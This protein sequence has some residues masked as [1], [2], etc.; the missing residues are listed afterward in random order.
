MKKLKL[1]A[2]IVAACAAMP[3]FAQTW[4]GTANYG[5]ETVGPFNTYDFSSA[6]VLLIDPV[7][8]TTANGYYQSFVTS[9]LLDDLKISSPL[10]ASNNYEITVVM[11]FT[12]HITSSNNFGKTFSIDGGSFALYLD[13]TPDR[14]F[15]TDSGFKDGIKILAGTVVSGATSTVKFGN[16]EIG[17]SDVQLMVTSYDASVFSSAIGGGENIFTLRM[18]SPLDSAFLNPITSVQGHS[19][20]PSTGDLKYAADANLILTPVPEPETYGMLL[21]GLGMLGAIARRRIS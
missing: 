14:S 15:N 5:V 7:N 19:Y 18:N 10:L 9:H 12:S 17:G 2:A 1:V 11:D 4:Q 6:G 16:Q 13:T 3:A 20:L 21:A 8:S